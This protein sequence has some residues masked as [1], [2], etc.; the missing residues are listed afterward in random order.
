MTSARLVPSGLSPAART[1]AG[2]APP[3][4]ER[5]HLRYELALWRAGLRH[6]AGVDEVGRGA[7]AGPLVAAAVVLPP[8]FEAPWLADLRDSKLLTPARRETLAALIRHDALAV[9]LGAVPA[10]VIDRAGLTAANHA[11]MAAAVAC[12]RCRPDFLLIDA[13]PLCGVEVDQAALIDGDACCVSVA[14]AAV[15]AK[16]VRDRLMAR[17]DAVVPGYGFAR[18]KGYGTA[19]HLAAL[20]R[21]GPSPLHRRSFAPLRGPGT[22]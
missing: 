14:C 22:T 15:V 18:H 10:A 12:L 11:A 5:P 16:V 2:I 13:V 9:G 21:L 3:D 7:L 6:V 20:A 1:P 19:E 4:D 17:H 8:F